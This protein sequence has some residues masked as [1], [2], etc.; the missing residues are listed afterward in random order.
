MRVCA[1]DLDDEEAWRRVIIENERAQHSL[2][3]LV[4]DADQLARR[5]SRK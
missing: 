3:A 2:Q 4:R 5:S 1:N